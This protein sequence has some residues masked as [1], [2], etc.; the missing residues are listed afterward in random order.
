VDYFQIFVITWQ[1]TFHSLRYTRS[2]FL[3]Q[4]RLTVS[5]SNVTGILVKSDILRTKCYCT[6]R[7]SSVY[8]ALLLYGTHGA[9]Y[10]NSNELQLVFETLNKLSSERR[11]Q[12]RDS[13]SRTYEWLSVAFQQ[14]EFVPPPLHQQWDS[15]TLHERRWLG[16]RRPTSVAVRL[17]VFSDRSTPSVSTARSHVLERASGVVDDRNRNG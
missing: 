1:T 5:L 15:V 10:L 17:C 12:H 16:W 14:I 13:I 7:S 4:V 8:K 3:F 6:F 11:N 2:K 9:P